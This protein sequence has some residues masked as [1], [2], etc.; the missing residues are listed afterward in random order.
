M[1]LLEALG[2]RVRVIAKVGCCGRPAIS[3]GQL[4]LARR[5]ARSNIA[6]LAGY[7]EQG[8]PIVGSEPSCLLTLRDEY[9]ELVPGRDADAVATQ[10]VLLD[11]VMG[12][13]AYVASGKEATFA[14]TAE[15]SLKYRRPVPVGSVLMIQGMLLRND[16]DNLFIR[17]EIL[18]PD[19]EVLT[20]AKARFKSL[21][22]AATSS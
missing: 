4:G 17:G 16:G 3:K 15:L 22:G 7:A 10:A 20:T 21:R 5:W 11:E 12:M 19:Q 6:L 18:G 2:Y 1:R 8:V 9:P 14:V 13:T